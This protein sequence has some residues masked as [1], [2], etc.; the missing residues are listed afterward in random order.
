MDTGLAK[1]IKAAGG[2]RPLA[3]KIGVSPAAIRQWEGRIPLNWV[4]TIEEATEVPRH[5]LRPDLFV[6]YVPKVREPA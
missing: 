5:R 6:G 4:L 2:V 3:R 1:A